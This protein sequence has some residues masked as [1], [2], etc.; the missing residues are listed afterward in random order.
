[1]EGRPVPAA[2]TTRSGA[3]RRPSVEDERGTSPRPRL[4]RPSTN[5]TPP[6]R[7]AWHQRAEERPVVDLMV[8]R[9]LEAAA[10]RRAERRDQAAALA[11]AAAVRLEAERVLVGEQVVE[12]GPI[13]GIERDRHRARRVVADGET[14]GGLE[15]RRRRRASWPAPSTSSAVRAD[16]PKCASV[17]GASMP[18]ATH[19]AP[20]RPGA[21]ATT[22]TS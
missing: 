10:Q 11:G 8:A 17:T 16:S 4:T 9:D 7:Q 18:A 1:M 2:R 6:S 13:G 12:A 14:G 3:R 20:S 5:V 15:R 19:D 22:V 21:G